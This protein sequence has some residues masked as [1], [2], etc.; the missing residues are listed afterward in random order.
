MDAALRD[1]V[2]G[3]IVKTARGFR[4]DGLA[5]AKPRDPEPGFARSRKLRRGSL[6][7][8]AAKTGAACVTRTRDPVI[9]NDVLYRLS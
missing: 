7:R 6:R 2:R 9:T 3:Q 4:E 5:K 8:C 1:G